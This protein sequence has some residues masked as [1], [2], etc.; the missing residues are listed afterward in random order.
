MASDLETFV[1]EYKIDSGDALKGLD[2]LNQRVGSFSK[3][4]TK[5]LG[6][7][8]DFA[9]DA[10]KE[11]GKLDPALS[12]VADGL[13]A[14]ARSGS[15][16]TLVFS[17]LV[18]VMKTAVDTNARFQQQRTAGIQTGLSG[19]QLQDNVN[20]L[21]FGNVNR[22]KALDH[23]RRSSD[24]AM[25]Y[26]TQGGKGSSAA[27][28]ELQR[29]HVS[30]FDANGRVL[31][32]QSL[33]SQL[34]EAY[35]KMSAS[36][37]R[38]SALALGFDPDVAMNM[39]SLGSNFNN[40]TL[41]NAQIDSY[42]KGS[43]AAQ[44]YTNAINKLSNDLTADSTSL[45][46][47]TL[48]AL[49]AL[50]NFFDKFT[51]KSLNAQ[52]HHNDLRDKNLGTIHAG[53][54]WWEATKNFSTDLDKASKMAD[55]QVAAEKK[56]DQDARNKR[57][58]DSNKENAQTKSDLGI[59]N[60]A[61][62]QFSDAVQTFSGIT[63]D[64]AGWAAWAGEVGRANG[65]GG[66]SDNFG[67]PG[68]DRPGSVTR[69]EAAASA[70]YSGGGTGTAAD[71]NNNP[72]NMEYGPFA[73]AHGATGSDGRFAIFPD[74]ATGTSAQQALLKSRMNAGMNTLSSVITSWAP[75]SDHNDTAGYIAEVAK[76][77]GIDPSKPFSADH[78]PAIAAAMAKR[79]GW[80]GARDS[81]A[82]GIMGGP[83]ANAWDV[84]AQPIYTINGP[85]LDRKTAFSRNGAQFLGIATAD[86]SDLG[87]PRNQVLT[88]DVSRKD[89]EWVQSIRL[90]KLMAHEGDLLR[91][92]QMPIAS[93][94]ERSN[95]SKSLMDNELAIS[96]LRAL[97]ASVTAL[98]NDGPRSLSLG[99][100]QSTI[101]IN[102][103]GVSDPNRVAEIVN[104]RLALQFHV[105]GS[106]TS[107]LAKR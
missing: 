83:M 60:L 44:D 34:S 5:G 93:P 82:A 106:S 28:L 45:G 29:L 10:T 17:G 96:N 13:S 19:V 94:A 14:I 43:K 95:L 59:L 91:Q 102:V 38:S 75:P 105:A 26:Y 100:Q 31:D 11:L 58:A 76:A 70:V 35:S 61:A 8:R 81:G 30:P 68:Q 22:E 64:K 24:L 88:G 57:V 6:S 32:T 2:K 73:K 85:V 71:R 67:M 97:G 20:K 7:I 80:H 40:T 54:T 48:P 104:Q 65:L 12:T 69:N 1:L 86:A 47:R 25:S 74:A 33:N 103:N 27:N 9:A 89:I 36:Q 50:S 16:A 87:I 52:E 90:A 98:G 101:T 78:I 18:A 3:D 62:S 63:S 66:K 56:A 51:D 42:E 37:T 4:A 46:Q 77:V 92:S 107:T 99:M 84:N 49:T 53:E 55:E 41:T 72:G 21:S 79:E 15:A 39:R 23:M